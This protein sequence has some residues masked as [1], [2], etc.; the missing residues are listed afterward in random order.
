M[1]ARFQPPFCPNPSCPRHAVPEAGEHQPFFERYGFYKPQC[2]QHPVQRFH[3]LDCGRTF[4]EQTFRQD[5]RDRRPELNIRLYESLVSS[6]GYRQSARILHMSA[7]GALRKARKIERQ[8]G[9][10]HEN[11]SAKLPGGRTYAFDELETFEHSKLRPVTMPVVVECASWFLVAH[12]VAPIRRLAQQGSERRQAQDELEA[13]EGIREDDSRECVHEVFARVDRRLNGGKLRVHTDQKSTYGPILSEIFGDRV[14]HVT[15][16]GKAKRDP[17]NP[18]FPIN[19]TL[20][21]CRD[22]L[23][24]LRRRTWLVS[25]K[26]EYL[27]THMQMF[28]VYRNYI[29]VRFNSDKS[30]CSS[31]SVLGLLPR[32]LTFEEVTRWRQ[33]W[34]ALSSHPLSADGRQRVGEAVAVVA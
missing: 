10:L 19:I 4:S 16:S 2:R 32:P 12:G 14:R 7:R 24:R 5:Y 33:D 17:S 28:T 25:K 23:G 21:M 1:Q 11:L 8:A 22:N 3:C 30:D 13:E 18:L 15:T 34:G 20:A 9:W 29:R 6:T 27:R 31:A 26:R